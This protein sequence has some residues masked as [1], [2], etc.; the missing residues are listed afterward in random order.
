MTFLA[1]GLPAELDGHR[2]LATGSHL[3]GDTGLVAM[4]LQ[5]QV[6]EEVVGGNMALNK[7]E[8]TCLTEE[9]ALQQVALVSLNRTEDAVESLVGLREQIGDRL[10]SASPEGRRWV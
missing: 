10:R 4:K 7:A 6:T 1:Y 5:G 3:S 2:G 8:R 9:I